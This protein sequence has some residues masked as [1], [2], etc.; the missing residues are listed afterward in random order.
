M[1]QKRLAYTKT[2]KLALLYAELSAAFPALAMGTTLNL[3]TSGTDRIEVEVPDAT[4]DVSVAA[5]I[6]AHNSA[7][8]TIE[9][10]LAARRALA[11]ELYTAL[12]WIYGK[13]PDEIQTYV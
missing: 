4:S 3:Y 2:F 9:E 8:L 5:V 1:A 7:T 10:I 6:T 11:K 13:T 12:P